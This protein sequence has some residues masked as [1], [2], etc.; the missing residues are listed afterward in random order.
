MT[1]AALL[2]KVDR[3]KPN[4]IAEADKLAKAWLVLVTSP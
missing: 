4:Q 3:L 2:A 1:I